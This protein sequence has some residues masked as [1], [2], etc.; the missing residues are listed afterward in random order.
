LA[1]PSG[2]QRWSRRWGKTLEGPVGLIKV[3]NV[4]SRED[5]TSEFY[6]WETVFKEVA[7]DLVK[8]GMWAVGVE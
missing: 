7:G 3:W 5:G 6:R 8:K 1:E 4:F 2:R